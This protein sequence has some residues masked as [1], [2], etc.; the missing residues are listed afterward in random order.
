MKKKFIRIISPITLIVIVLLDIA[1]IGFAFFSVKKI[2]EVQNLYS[3]FFAVIEILAIIVAVLVTKETIC[4]GIVF[5]EDKFEF[6]GIDDKNIFLY[7][8][9]A[10]IETYKDTKASLKKNFIDRHSLIII[11]L[12]DDTVATVDIGLTSKKI[13]TKFKKELAEYISKEKIKNT[14]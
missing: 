7:S 1:V 2:I 12:N 13:L 14:Q 11:T 6:T 4:N 8:D 5:Y 3:I 10:E 9:I